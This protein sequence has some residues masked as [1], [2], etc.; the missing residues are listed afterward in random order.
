M[1]RPQS[2]QRTSMTSVP[3]A[4]MPIRQPTSRHHSHSVSLG[5]INGSHRVTRR[6]SMTS[7]VSNNAAAF[8]A[9]INSGAS[10]QGTLGQKNRR[11]MPVKPSGSNRAMDLMSVDNGNQGEDKDT[12]LMNIDNTDNSN[13]GCGNAM[14]GSAVSD[15]QLLSERGDPG[16]K[17]RIRRASEGAHLAKGE[18]KRTSGEL[19]CEKCGKGY[20]HSSC[21]TKHLSVSSQFPHFGIRPLL[22]PSQT[23]LSI[24]LVVSRIPRSLYGWI[25]C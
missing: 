20:K 5:T 8:K 10:I 24:A 19:R 16:C 13:Q 25:Y 3:A 12:V 2:Q 6:K 4:N 1:P 14:G 9:A 22:A 18:S 7:T 17:A 15:G 11:S 23:R 21:L